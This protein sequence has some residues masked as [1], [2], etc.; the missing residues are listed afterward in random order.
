MTAEDYH[1]TDEILENLHGVH[2][3]TNFIGREMNVLQ[4]KFD[5]KGRVV[6]L[7]ADK[8]SGIK[9][10]VQQSLIGPMDGYFF[11]ETKTDDFGF[12]MFP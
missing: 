3:A 10:R 6:C 9:I 5:V 7:E 11:A 2:F 1:F 8:C 12:Y 4:G